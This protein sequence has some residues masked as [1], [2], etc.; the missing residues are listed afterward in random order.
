MSDDIVLRTHGGLGNQIFQIFY[1]LCESEAFELSLIKVVHDDRY[2]HRFQLAK[3]F[4][5]CFSL[6]SLTQRIISAARC[7]KI[8]ERTGLSSRGTMTI[9]GTR[10]FDGYFQASSF[11]ESHSREVI[12]SS[13]AR[14]KVLL[15]GEESIECNGNTLH[16]VRL[17]DFFNTESEEYNAALRRI[18]SVEP[19]SDI[20]TNRE[21]IV[22]EIMKKEGCDAALSLVK[23]EGL[24]GLQVLKLMTSYSTIKTNDSTLA[25]WAAVL[26]DRSLELQSDKLQELFRC[27]TGK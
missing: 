13:I 10:Y 26:A 17:G 2:S 7:P 14:L 12:M 18:K 19:G 5:D 16:H 6:P 11:Y 20:M 1:A 9:C 27:L 23:T 15:L 3:P 25:F 21:R 4:T 24:S 22:H 8:S